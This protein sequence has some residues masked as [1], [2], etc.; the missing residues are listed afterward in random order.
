[1]RRSSELARTTG[2][3]DPLDNRLEIPATVSAQVF[4]QRP[5]LVLSILAV[6]HRLSMR[7]VRRVSTR[8]PKRVMISRK[9]ESMLLSRAESLDP[10][11]FTLKWAFHNSTHCHRWDAAIPSMPAVKDSS[12]A[13]GVE[14]SFS[15]VSKMPAAMATGF[16]V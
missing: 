12:W 5:S 10:M 7:P 8:W 16:E 14:S 3:G 2:I 11:L 6:A 13:K 1:M 4:L 15:N 9:E